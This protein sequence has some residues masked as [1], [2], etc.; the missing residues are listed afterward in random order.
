MCGLAAALHHPYQTPLGSLNESYAYL[1]ILLFHQIL[2]TY[3]LNTFYMTY[4]ILRPK[5]VVYALL[6]FV[7]CH[8]S[9]TTA[10]GWL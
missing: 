2:I 7:L 10:L 3:L 1:L 6:V 4:L 9:Q 5:N 8:R